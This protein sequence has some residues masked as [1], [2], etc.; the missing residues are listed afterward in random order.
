MQENQE[1]V[2][3]AKRNVRR[4][5]LLMNV[6]LICYA[7]LFAVIVFFTNGYVGSLAI[8]LLM[9]PGLKVK[10]ALVNRYLLSV[11]TARL[12]NETFYAMVRHGRFDN[13]DAW[14][15]VTAEYYCGNYQ[16]VFSI[17]RRKQAASR[18]KKGMLFFY[19]TRLAEVYFDIG[20]DENLRKIVEQ[21][22]FW[23]ARTKP[24]ARR[25]IQE[26]FSFLTFCESYLL[27]DADACMAW[28]NT[29]PASLLQQYRRTFC[30]AR[31][32]HVQG[33]VEEARRYY[34]V[35][36]KEIP[37][38]NW[39]KLAAKY[40]AEMDGQT[41]DESFDSFSVSG[42]VTEIELYSVGRAKMILRWI[43]WITLIFVLNLSAIILQDVRSSKKEQEE[44]RESIRAM[45][46]QEY[47]GIEIL[48]YAY[49]EK[50]NEPFDSMFIGM[51]DEILVFG[52][53]Y[54]EDGIGEL[55]YVVN[56][57]IPIASLSWD[58]SPILQES[59]LTWVSY[60]VVEVCFYTDR[61]QVPT[62]NYHLSSFDINGQK[63]YFAVT[64]LMTP[65]EIGKKNHENIRTLVKPYYGDVEVLDLS[66][67][68]YGGTDGSQIVF[69]CQTNTHII[70][71][72][73]PT[74]FA[75]T[76]QYEPHL[77]DIS[78]ADLFGGASSVLSVSLPS[79]ISDHTTVYWF[80][81]V[82]DD[83][84]SPFGADEVLEINGQKVYVYDETVWPD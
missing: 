71:G 47:D 2:K 5:Y 73:V 67:A 75:E 43:I 52:S 21:Y 72:C 84:P 42:E 70:I 81:M 41:S 14:W 64:N 22:H 33:N 49:L 59:F 80:S 19:L 12:D 74:G 63:V 13:R 3:R 69:I 57:E 76:W 78:I 48:D 58:Q 18:V 53:L 4:Y 55:D 66:S 56:A 29:I 17:C 68:S 79:S 23:I 46:E 30:K 60:V 38:L 27:Q 25:S 50:Q 8:L 37:Q 11:L 82:E 39:G 54:E 7:L 61:T 24:R 62:E 28:T 20:D 36:A 9:I 31:L 34:E 77:V 6:M 15:Q 1:M 44:W 10:G 32:S 45:V 16:N 83:L 40:L 65:E 35:M 51:T 26:K